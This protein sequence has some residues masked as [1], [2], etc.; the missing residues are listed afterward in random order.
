VK[1]ELD[2]LRRRVDTLEVRNR[3]ALLMAWAGIVL[4]QQSGAD[5]DAALTALRGVGGRSRVG[6]EVEGAFDALN[7]TLSTH[8]ELKPAPQPAGIFL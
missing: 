7:A 8:P 6:R 4:H 5:E 1:D 3:L 2:D